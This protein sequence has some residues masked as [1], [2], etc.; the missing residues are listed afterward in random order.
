MREGIAILIIGASV[1]AGGCD[2]GGQARDEAADAPSTAQGN[3]ADAHDTATAPAVGTDSHAHGG[4]GEPRSLLAIMQQ[5]GVDMTS[6]TH[7]L[8]TDDAEM[9]AHAAET[10][11]NHAPIA[12]EDIERIHDTLGDEMVEFERLDDNVHELSVRLYDAAESGDTDQVLTLLNEV[13]RGC[14]ACHTQFRERLRTN[15]VQ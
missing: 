9:V 2:T 6:L 12:P 7:G 13:Q 3:E 5:L 11:A 1:L 4:S 8:M 10:I 15:A 14:V